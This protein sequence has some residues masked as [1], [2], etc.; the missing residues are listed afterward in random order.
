MWAE[1][2][3]GAKS[4]VT[5]HQLCFKGNSWKVIVRLWALLSVQ[6]FTLAFKTSRQTRCSNRCSGY[7]QHS[8]GFG[9]RFRFGSRYMNEAPGSIWYKTCIYYAGPDMRLMVK[10]LGFRI[11]WLRFCFHNDAGSV[12]LSCGCVAVKRGV[13]SAAQVLRCSAAQVLRCS[14]RIKQ[15]CQLSPVTNEWSVTVVLLIHYVSCD[16][17]SF[18]WSLVEYMC[19]VFHALTGV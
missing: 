11:Q 14:G 18:I 15:T 7:C 16:L 10:T 17:T 2:S 5:A 6:F 19:Q 3:T 13:F 8:D 9:Y 1:H 4:Q 12:L